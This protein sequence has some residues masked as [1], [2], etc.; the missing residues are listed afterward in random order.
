MHFKGKCAHFHHR[1]TL[2]ARVTFI[3]LS[4]ERPYLI[5]GLNFM[6]PTFVDF[7]AEICSFHQIHGFPSK[8]T[9]FSQKPQI[10]RVRICRFHEIHSF[11]SKTMVFHD[12]HENCGFQPKTMDFAVFEFKTRKFFISFQSRERIER[13]SIFFFF[14]LFFGGDLNL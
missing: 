9:V 10:S 13:V 6:I 12:F 8:T 4:F 1:C 7:A 2:P 11:P 3:G 5:K 14:F